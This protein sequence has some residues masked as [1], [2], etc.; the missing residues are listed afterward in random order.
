MPPVA[1]MLFGHPVSPWM[2]VDRWCQSLTKNAWTTIEVRDG[3]KGPLTIEAVKVR[4]RAKSAD[5]E[6]GG[7]VGRDSRA[8]GRRHVEA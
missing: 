7:N 2:R 3:E 5:G 1:E 6:L 4:V 8:P